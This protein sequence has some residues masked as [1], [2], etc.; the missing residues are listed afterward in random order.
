MFHGDADGGEGGDDYKELL[1]ANEAL[2]EAG[3]STEEIRAFANQYN[4][5]ENEEKYG[6]MRS[7]MNAAIRR[8]RED[9]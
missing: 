7:I 6:E 5:A 3:Y 1:A 2:R 9:T 4:Y 8:Y